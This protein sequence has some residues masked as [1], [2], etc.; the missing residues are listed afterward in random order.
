MSYT[1]KYG[2]SITPDFPPQ[3]P[4]APTSVLSMTVVVIEQLANDGTGKALSHGTGFMWRAADGL[5]LITAKHVLTGRNPFDDTHLSA[6][7]FE[8]SEIKVHFG[9]GRGSPIY[10]RE[11]WTI[12]LYD[13]D[14]CPLWSE[15]PEFEKLK[16][17]IAA[18]PIDLGRSDIFCINDEPDF[19][20]YDN[21]FTHVGFQCFV[22]G[23]PTLAVS[24]FM[25]PIWRSGSIASDPRVAI[26]GKPIFLLDAATGP[27]FSGSPVW[28]LQIG[29]TA[30]HD[31]SLPTGIRIDSDA[32]IRPSF[33]GVYA[34][35]LNHPHIGAQTP[36]VFY[37]NRIPLILRA[38]AGR[39]RVR[40]LL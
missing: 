24:G 1:P 29:P 9:V 30:F 18:L 26:D 15:D 35:R 22:V 40:P 16:T 19:G 17:D 31:S 33:V 3:F 32:V 13:K 11:A 14:K 37:A 10:G 34:G 7:L 2:G 27:G 23:Y 8:P 36:Y 5:W 21:M 38:G 28:R 20:L 6:T 12:P 39:A 4:E 25:L